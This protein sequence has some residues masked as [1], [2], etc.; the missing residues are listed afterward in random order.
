MKRTLLLASAILATAFVVTSCKK[1]STEDCFTCETKTASASQSQKVCEADF[2]KAKA[3]DTSMKNV[4]WSQ[5]KQ[6][7][8][9]VDALS[10]EMTCSGL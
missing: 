8:K 9:A 5:Y 4:T 3:S 1:D 10:T 6:L 2:N 7:F